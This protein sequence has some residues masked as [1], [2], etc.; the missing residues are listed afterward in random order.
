MQPMR[1]RV[2]L[3]AGIAEALGAETL[4]VDAD[5]G[6]TASSVI[7]QLAAEH[8]AIAQMRPVLAVAIND[9]YAPPGTP[10][11]DGDTLALIPPV[12]GG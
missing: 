10:L 5:D 6:A 7:D 8:A 4:T 9:A 3:F 1:C 2:L 11:H 12:S